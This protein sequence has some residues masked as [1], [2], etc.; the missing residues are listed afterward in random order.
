MPFSGIY[1]G[2]HENN[3]EIPVAKLKT[4]RSLA[5]FDATLIKLFQYTGEL[6]Q[7]PEAAVRVESMQ[8]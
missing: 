4:G 1:L 7:V 8:N 6:V 5:R 2:K 3:D